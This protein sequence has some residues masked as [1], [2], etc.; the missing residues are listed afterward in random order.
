MI[1]NPSFPSTPRACALRRHRRHR[2]RRQQT[3][4]VREASSARDPQPLELRL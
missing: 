3:K 4:V 1:G 2:R